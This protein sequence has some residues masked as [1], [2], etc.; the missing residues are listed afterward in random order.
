M[1]NRALQFATSDPKGP[2]Y[3]MGARE[4][5]EEVI[6]PYSVNPKNWKPVGPSAL[7]HDAVVEIAEILV[8]A[9][10][11]LVVTGYSGRNHAA[12][13]ALVG[14]ADLVK[15]LR[16]LDTGGCD[17]CFPSSH[18]GWLGM[19]YGAD[20]SIKTADV[21]LVV[22]CDVPWVNT[23]C[24]PRA[25][26]KIIHFDVDPLKQLMPVF[27]IDAE[28]RHRVD[29]QTA[30][31]QLVSHLKSSSD[32]QV[33]LSGPTF[34]E[35][36][37][38]LQ[39]SH[40]Q[41]IQS[42]DAKAELAHADQMSSAYV[43]AAIRKLAPANS[44]FAIEAVTN[45]VIAAEQIRPTMAGQW[46]NCGGGGLG[47]SGGGALGIKLAADAA[48]AAAGSASKRLVVQI[49]GDGSYLFSVPSSV[50][51][52]SKRYN[53]PILTIVL[54]NKGTWM[55]VVFNLLARRPWA[56]SGFKIPLLLGH[57]KKLTQY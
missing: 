51:W 43:C 32:L 38:A 10:E 1:V 49:V 34:E 26:A 48:D 25:D 40:T 16:V 4:V 33:Q 3:L 23:Q 53:I 14:L 44:I 19:K 29:A 13:E 47:W 46:V 6:E 27:Y 15:G 52:I 17:M 41:L 20:E 31:A 42:L 55:P 28:L 30:L 56:G 54:N 18:P 39:K 5:M 12:V 36:S 37:I 9:K 7:P 21:I 11:P 8:Q 2:V 45:S 35:R 50:Y 24:K 22:D 57:M